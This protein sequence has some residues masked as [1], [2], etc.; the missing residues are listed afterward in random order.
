MRCTICNAK[1]QYHGGTTSMKEHLRRKH[2]S[3]D[4]FDASDRKHKQR[5]L[6]IF[7]KNVSAQQNELEQSVRKLQR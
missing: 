6:D 7:T 4:P 1:L 3:D 5:K 2:P